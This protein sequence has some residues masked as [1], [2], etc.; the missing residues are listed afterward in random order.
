MMISNWEEFE[1]GRYHL[2]SHEDAKLL[3]LPSFPIKIL[4]CDPIE[5]EKKIP[6]QNLENLIKYSGKN[7]EINRENTLD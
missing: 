4:D 2:R 7:S 5:V 3:N 1:H 6:Q